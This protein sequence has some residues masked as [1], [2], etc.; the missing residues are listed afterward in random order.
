V[1]LDLKSFTDFEVIAQSILVFVAERGD[2]SWVLTVDSGV[3]VFFVLC[4]S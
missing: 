4:D 1:L 3:A 2:G